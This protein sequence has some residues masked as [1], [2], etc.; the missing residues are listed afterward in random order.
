MRILDASLYDFPKYYDLLF[1]SDWKAEFDF[2]NM[3]FQKY[4]RRPVRALFEPACGTGRLLIRFASAGYDV[5]GNDLNAKAVGYCNA[6]LKRH[7]FSASATIGDMADFRLPR[8]VDAIFNTINS[9]RHLRTERAAEDHLRCVSSALS[10]G[11]LY[12]LGFHLTPAGPATCDEES[13][14]ARRG[15]LAVCSRMRSLA[16]DCRRRCE[17]VEMA[18]DIY[19]PTRQFRLVEEMVFRTYTAQQFQCLLGRIEGLE[20]AETHDFAYDIDHPVRVDATTED[21]VY[22]LRRR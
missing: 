22:V 14:S 19:T 9:F 12:V 15:H 6:R 1:G 10:P 2:L 5:S 8:T 4:A 18:V 11:G 7:G 20:L 17:H 21:V 3:C 13:W 16:L